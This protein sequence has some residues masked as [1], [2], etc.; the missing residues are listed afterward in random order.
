MFGQFKGSNWQK[1]L[2]RKGQRKLLTRTQS[3]HPVR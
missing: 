1:V 3:K 2:A